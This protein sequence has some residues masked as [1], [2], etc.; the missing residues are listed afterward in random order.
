[1]KANTHITM[2]SSIAGVLF[3]FGI[4]PKAGAAPEQPEYDIVLALTADSA[5]ALATR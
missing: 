1:M 4:F 5:K 2:I 3:G